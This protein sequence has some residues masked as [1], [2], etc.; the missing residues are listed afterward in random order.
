MLTVPTNWA[1]AADVGT[2]SAQKQPDVFRPKSRPLL[3][4]L[5]LS[6]PQLC[7]GEADCAVARP[8]GGGGGCLRL[9]VSV[10]ECV[11][12][13]VCVCACDVTIL[14]VFVYIHIYIYIHTCLSLPFRAYTR[15]AAFFFTPSP[16]FPFHSYTV[17]IHTLTDCTELKAYLGSVRT[18]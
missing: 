3:V 17:Y 10:R 13:C 2:E 7:P 11:R 18:C 4:S 12:V 16:F 1:D 5:S 14:C 9:C 15:V 6:Q 8:K